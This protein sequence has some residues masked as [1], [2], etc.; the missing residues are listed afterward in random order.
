[1]HDSDGNE[2]SDHDM[3]AALLWS[4]YKNRMGNSEGI[5]M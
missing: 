2:V 3:M 5:E 4:E 1:L